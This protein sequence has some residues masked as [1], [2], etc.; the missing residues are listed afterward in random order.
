MTT[1]DP[2]YDVNPIV[3]ARYLGAALLFGMLVI[4][5]HQA[6]VT[7]LLWAGASFMVGTVAGLLFGIPRTLQTRE[8]RDKAYDQ[9][10]NTNLEEISDWL[11]KILVG[12]GLTQLGKIRWML[13]DAA[14]YVAG[15]LGDAAG[16][17]AFAYGLLTYF[18]LVGFIGAYL[19]AR[20]FLPRMFRTAEGGLE[21]LVRGSEDLGQFLGAA[22]PAKTSGGG[23]L[24]SGGSADPSGQ[25]LA[26]A[27]KT[28]EMTARILEAHHDLE[29]KEPADV[30][31]KHIPT[32]EAAKGDMPESRALFVI[33]GR[34]YRWTGDLGKAIA[35]LTEFID[36]KKASGSADDEDTAM[37]YYNRA[38]YYAQK[39]V[40][41]RQK[42]EPESVAADLMRQSASD[43]RDALSRMPKYQEYVVTDPDLKVLVDAY[44]EFRRT[45]A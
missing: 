39:A 2:R 33:L 10:V 35:T 26:E 15:G 23:A 28:V 16:Q 17:R 5:F 45:Q 41:S 7:A 12:L 11:T 32:L 40:E 21:G 44:P 22:Q 24:S 6:R 20:I 3:V 37:A 31:R 19:L 9:R 29:K 1:P 14:S 8:L 25:R 34:L 30:L 42:E 36:R 43:L 13:Q 4:V 18:S 38:C 27:S